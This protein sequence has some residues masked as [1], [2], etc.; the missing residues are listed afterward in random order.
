M[1][2]LYGVWRP[3]NMMRWQGVGGA[4]C[5]RRWSRA[6]IG[7]LM[8][9]AGALLQAQPPGLGSAPLGAPNLPPPGAAPLGPSVPGNARDARSQAP[10]DLTGYWVSIVTE[11]WRYRMVVP[12]PGYYA[13]IPMTLAAK[14]SADAWSRARDEAAGKQC[15]AYGAAAIMRVPERLRISWQDP[16]TLEVQTDAGMQTRLL[17]FEPT[18]Q[19]ASAPPSLQG[20]SVAHWQVAMP[21]GFGPVPR[22]APRYGSLAVTTTRMTGGLLRTN[23]VPYSGQSS[24]MEQWDLNTERSGD[25]WLTVSSELTDPVDLRAPYIVTATFKKQ[26]DAAG[27]DPSPCTLQ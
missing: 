19:Q 18:P 9:S 3:V 20:L 6:L 14:Q 16:N 7:M 5:R 24:L 27:W 10:I 11:D 8:L 4:R 15:E 26:K 12:G 25:A 13:G 21:G 1:R 22:N 17:R 23:G 2:T